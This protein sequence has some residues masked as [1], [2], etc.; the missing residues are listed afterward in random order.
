MSPPVHVTFGVSGDG[1]L[2]TALR[3]AGCRDRVVPLWDDL[4]L[5]PIDPPELKARWAWAR[6]ELGLFPHSRYL[7]TKKHNAWDIALS[8]GV[9]RIAWVSRRRAHE[10][11]GF[12]E[13]LWRL[14]D[15]PCDIVDLHDVEFERHRRDGR[16]DRNSVDCLAALFAEEIFRDA[17]WDLAKPLTSERRRHYRGI[18]EK[19]RTENA[20]FRVLKDEQL[21]SAP[22]SHYDDVILGHTG[23]DLRK[24]AWVIRGPKE[25]TPA[26]EACEYIYHGRLHYLVAT[27]VLEA[28][29]DI[30]KPGYSEVRRMPKDVANTSKSQAS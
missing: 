14:G 15:E 12:L 11:C 29:G 22:M 2:R 7:F 23:D 1:A 24:V 3:E 8:T 26:Y 18:W 27:G 10:Y 16:V 21:V 5:G 25:P 20:P 17:L 9:R 13:W 28:Q 19:L 4:S 30:A 6:R